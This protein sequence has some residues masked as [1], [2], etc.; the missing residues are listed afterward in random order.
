M[1]LTAIKENKTTSRVFS[2]VVKE[3]HF[4]LE[5]ESCN[6]NSEGN[7]E[8]EE[9]Y[10]LGSFKYVRTLPYAKNIEI[11]MD[12][13]GM[14]TQDKFI[15]IVTSQGVA[16]LFGKLLFVNVTDKGEYTP[17]SKEQELYLTENLIA[18]SFGDNQYLNNK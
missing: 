8:L 4:A 14:Y 10:R 15:N 1:E 17:L 12:E 7:L 6:L 18:M 11:L 9:I 16:T 3:N 2:T 5:M 13:N